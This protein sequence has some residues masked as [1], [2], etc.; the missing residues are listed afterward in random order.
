MLR[1]E[2]KEHIGEQ[3]LEAAFIWKSIIAL[4][5]TVLVLSYFV[6]G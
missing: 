3:A 2:L 6:A 1:N 5:A 4:I